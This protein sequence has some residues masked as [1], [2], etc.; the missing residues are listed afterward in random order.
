[1]GCNA[2]WFEECRCNLSK[3]E[4]L[5]F[6]V[7]K[8]GIEINQNKT[9]AI[10]NASPPGNKKQLQSLLGKINFLRRFISNLSSRTKIFS[11]LVKLKKE[12]KFKWEEEH[13]NA[14]EEIKTYLMNPHVLLPPIKNRPMKLYIAASDL[15]I[16]SML[17]QEDDNGVERAIYYLSRVLNDA[18][19]RYSSIEKLCLCLYF[20]YF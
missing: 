8:K 17:A 3:G 7:H 14:F 4:F 19:T 2:L 6:V 9:K 5:G 20:S 13:Q 10:F 1:M 12:E 18:E 11:P 15:T 16:G